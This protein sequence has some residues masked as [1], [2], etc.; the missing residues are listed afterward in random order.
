MRNIIYQYWKGPMKPGVRASTKLMKEYADRIGAEYRFDHNTEMASQLV[1]IPIYY[2][3]ANPLVD[4]FFD[5]FDNV[6]LVDIDVFPVEGLTQNIFEELNG[7][8]AGIC[9]EPMQPKFRQIY[10]VAGITN[11]NDSNWAAL[12]KRQWN[13]EYSRDVDGRPMVYNTG[14]VIIS[15][16]GLAKM[17]K[18]WPTFQQYVNVVRK[19]GFPKFYL[20]FQDYFSAFIHMK[21]FKFKPLDNGWNSYV[22]KLGSHPNATVNDTRTANTKL[23]HIMF[24]TADDWPEESLWQITNKPVSEWQLPVNKNWPNDG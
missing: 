4:G 18:E 1:D 20:L 19:A 21:G 3:P 6:A 13:I 17:K 11:S 23:V 7:E 14:V 22:H 16:N 8:D 10:N 2:E 9:T 24:R 15:K 5:K 12:L